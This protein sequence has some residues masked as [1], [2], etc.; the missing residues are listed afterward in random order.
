MRIAQREARDR[1]IRRRPATSIDGVD[2]G[3][4][5][6]LRTTAPAD[7]PVAT[8]ESGERA[9]RLRGAVAG[10]PAHYRDAVHLRYLDGLS[11]EEIAAATGRPEPTIRTHL[12]RGLARLR[13]DLGD[14]IQ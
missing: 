9:A 8:A 13:A 7:D 5:D 11:F 1:A 3:W 10:L 12:H 4:P 6:T 14:D 2:D